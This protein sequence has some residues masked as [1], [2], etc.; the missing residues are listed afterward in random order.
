MTPE[1]IDDL[2]ERALERGVIPAEATAEERAEVQRLLNQAAALK[3]NASLIEKEAS[4]ALPTARARFQRHLAEQRT[5]SQAPV[6]PIR[7]PQRGVFGRWLGG[8]GMTFAG[9]AIG[10][11]V[12][13]VFALLVI[14]PFGGVESASALTIDDYVQVEGVVS[15]TNNGSVTVQSSDLGNLEIALS[16]LTAVSDASGVRQ[17]NTLQPGDS[18]LVSGVV[19]A[20]RE[21]A[22]SNVAVAPNGGVPTPAAERKIPLLK[23][24]RPVQGIVSLIALSPDGSRARVLLKAATERVL[25]DIDARSMD[26]FLAGTSRPLGALVRLVEAPDLP[27]G[28]FRLQPVDGPQ[29]T[30]TADAGGKTAPQFQGVRGIVVSRNLNVLMVRTDRGIVPVVIRPNTSIRFGNSGLTP[31]DIR[32]G[33]PVIGYEVAI[34]GNPDPESP[35]RVLASIIVVIGKPQ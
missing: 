23:D 28:V 5:P 29:A 9:S 20:K 1:R 30:P 31:D 6:A 7:S 16:E 2:L 22:A 15:A 10:V 21:I 18:I 13:A 26:E 24:F 27:N 11:A 33:E 25:V 19:T 17:A 12:L 14:Q 34:T 35:R 3:R 4:A 32:N 8:R